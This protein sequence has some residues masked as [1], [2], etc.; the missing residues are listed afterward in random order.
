MKNERIFLVIIIVQL[1]VTGCN[2]EFLDRNPKTSLTEQNFWNSEQ[3]LKT[4]N[5]QLYAEYFQDKGFGNND[6]M[7]SA[8]NMSDNSFTDNPGDVR[9]G[10][11][12]AET[13]GIVNWDWSLVRNINVFL[14]NYDRTDIIEKLRNK[15]AAEVRLLRALDYYDKIK[16]YGKLPLIDR[17]PSENDELLYEKQ[18]SRD[19]I[20][21]FVMEDLNFAIEWLPKSAEKNRF[22]RYVALAYKARICLHEGTFRKYHGLGNEEFYLQNALDASS[23]VINSGRYFIDSTQSYHSLFS[24]LDL[25]GNKEIIYYK[26]YSDEQQLY[27]NVAIQ[28]TGNFGGSFSG[29]K[30][31][32]NDYLCKDGLPISESTLYQGDENISNEFANR[33]ERLTG[34]FALPNTYFMSDKIY[35]NSSPE[36]IG[37]TACPSG[38]Q[39]VKFFN[40]QQ[41]ESVA[42][43]RSYLD[44]PLFRYAEVLLIYAETKIELGDITQNDLDKSINL[45]RAKAN[46]ADMKA[47]QATLEEIRR[48]RRVELAFEGFRY[49]DLMRWKQGDLL[50]EPVLGLKFNA[51]DIADY[52]AFEV[53]NHVFLN[54]EGYIKSNNNYNF[55]ENKHYYFPIPV[56]EL[57]L[58]PN[59]EQT[60]GWEN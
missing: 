33:D 5:N 37:I 1:L 6:L 13:P 45:L 38:Y 23:E 58:N 29:T 53:G 15:Y 52:E 30:S 14:E 42:W 41:E 36:P 40:Q 8:D 59:L 2:D 16:L 60:E 22:D 19:E 49:D 9:L 11:H 47:E 56:N 10:I 27:H 50:S 4:Y 44:A 18:K 12:T 7:L 31:L 48:E 57:S 46:V 54:E 26:D 28:I 34:T 35:L 32:I 51:D 20:L 39:V 3:D 21:S 17:V 43:G 24:N 55:D 25:A